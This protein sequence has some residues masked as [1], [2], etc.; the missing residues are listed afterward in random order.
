MPN[1]NLASS[2][3]DR[4]QSAQF[5]CKLH[6]LSSSLRR[7]LPAAKLLHRCWRPAGTEGITGWCSDWTVNPKAF[8]SCH[9]YIIVNE[10]YALP[11]SKL[12][13]PP[14]SPRTLTAY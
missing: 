7:C 12:N 8:N 3:L 1:L 6:S 9:P 2:I 13:D 4:S 14:C 11:Q 10:Q 5:A